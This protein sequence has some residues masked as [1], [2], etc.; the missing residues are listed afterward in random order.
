MWQKQPNTNR[1][2]SEK[3]RKKAHT[4]KNISKNIN[5]LKELLYLVHADLAIKYDEFTKI[6]R[7][8]IANIKLYV[9]ELNNQIVELTKK[10]DIV[11]DF[12]NLRKKVN[13]L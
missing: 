8:K 13:D 10:M 6:N 9:S 11:L 4:E 3:F 12:K 5:D 7:E 2:F 1:I